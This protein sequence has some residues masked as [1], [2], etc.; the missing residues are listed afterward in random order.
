MMLIIQEPYYVIKT[1]FALR[2]YFFQA[3]GSILFP[4]PPRM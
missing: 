4:H 1:D 2:Y 3:Q